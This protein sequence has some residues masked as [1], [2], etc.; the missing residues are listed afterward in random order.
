MKIWSLPGGMYYETS[1]R[2]HAGVYKIA[3]SFIQRPSGCFLSGVIYRKPYSSGFT[4]V[5]MTAPLNNKTLLNNC[6]HLH[7]Y[8]EYLLF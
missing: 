5:G 8:F 6:Q 4:L 2:I 1:T 7:D 3:Y